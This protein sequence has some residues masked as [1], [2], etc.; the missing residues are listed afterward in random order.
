MTWSKNSTGYV[1]NSVFEHDFIGVYSNDAHD[2]KI[3]HDKFYYN[4]LYG[5][6]P[7]SGSSNLLIE[8]NVADYNGR[9]GIIFSDHVTNGV[10]KYNITDGN[11]LNGIMMDEAST[12]NV[13]EDNTVANNNSDGVVLASSSSNVICDNLIRGNRVGITVRGNTTQSKIC[14][15]TISA[16]K[17]ASEGADLSGNNAYGNGGEWSYQRI[18]HI[19]LGA[20]GLLLSLL[21]L[22]LGMK[23][24]ARSGSES[25]T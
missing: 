9:H 6:D 16:N 20:V 21:I 10:V 15:N 14:G 23:R 5:V 2:L 22:T 8:Y 17:M 7:H 18:S 25:H 12:G 4:S 13:I 11:G 3:L 1:T 19:W 24:R